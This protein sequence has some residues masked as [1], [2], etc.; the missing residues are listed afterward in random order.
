MNRKA[1][2][3]AIKRCIKKNH[4]K[5]KKKNRHEKCLY[6]HTGIDTYKMFCTLRGAAMAIKRMHLGQ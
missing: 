1:L 6:C 5:K 4:T 2:I 3:L